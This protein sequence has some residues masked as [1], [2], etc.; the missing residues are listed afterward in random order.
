MVLF[1]M[2]CSSSKKTIPNEIKKDTTKINQP[3]FIKEVEEKFDL[4]ERYIVSG[5][6][7]SFDKSDS[8]NTTD[9]ITGEF[10]RL[11]E[12][13]KYTVVF[14][15]FNSDSITKERS[16]EEVLAVEISEFN[17]G[18]K[19]YPEKFSFFLVSY[20]EEKSRIDG[21]TIHGYITF[22][23]ISDKYAEGYFDFLIDGVKKSFDKDD[24]KV[25]VVFSGNFKLPVTEFTRISR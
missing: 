6:S 15:E 23:K 24:I 22:R 8:V 25:E 20:G 10:I 18:I 1:L 13:N 4:T 11:K 9:P 7:I 2:G 5:S 17:T 14:H 12:G 3:N 19:Y 16:K 21:K